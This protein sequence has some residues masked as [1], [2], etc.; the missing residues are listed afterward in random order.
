MS[1]KVRT[2][3]DAGAKTTAIVHRAET[4]ATLENFSTERNRVAK[5][6]ERLSHQFV[7]DAGL[8]AVNSQ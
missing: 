3:V 8:C 2:T 1:R 4:Y 7:E 5:Q 6:I